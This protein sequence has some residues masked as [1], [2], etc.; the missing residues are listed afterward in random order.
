MAGWQAGDLVTV[1]ECGDDGRPAPVGFRFPASVAAVCGGLVH[2]D[3]ENGMTPIGAFH[4]ATGWQAWDG[5]ARWRLYHRP[6]R[7]SPR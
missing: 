4:A 7:R 2:V 6:A 1:T 5:P 3:Y